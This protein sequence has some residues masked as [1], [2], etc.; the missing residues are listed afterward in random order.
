[1]D[2][3]TMATTFNLVLGIVIGIAIGVW[4]TKGDKHDEKASQHDYK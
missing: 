1:M 2:F 3:L 4:A